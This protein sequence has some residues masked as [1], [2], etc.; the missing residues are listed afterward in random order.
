MYCY[1]YTPSHT[2]ELHTKKIVK[3]GNSDTNTVRLVHSVSN[4]SVQIVDE[5]QWLLTAIPVVLFL[6][7]KRKFNNIHYRR[8]QP[9]S[10]TSIQLYGMYR[11]DQVSCAI[12]NY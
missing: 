6:A 1:S 11:I 5:V 9:L 8:M 2:F 12:R 3:A 4:V 10:L 7:K